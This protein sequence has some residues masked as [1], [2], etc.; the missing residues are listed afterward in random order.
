MVC[1][2]LFYVDEAP[3]NE[4]LIRFAEMELERVDGMVKEFVDSVLYD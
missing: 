3:K 4:Y 2:D 1:T